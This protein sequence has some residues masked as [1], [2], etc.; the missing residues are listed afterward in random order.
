MNPLMQMMGGAKSPMNNIQSMLQNVSNIKRLMQ[1]RDPNAMVQ[2]L[3]QNNPQFAQFIKDNEGKSPEQIASDY[4][5][6]W[7]MVQSFLK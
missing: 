2:M 1:G 3:S 5:L 6:D 7:N 4:G